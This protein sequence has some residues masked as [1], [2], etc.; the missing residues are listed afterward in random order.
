[1]Y[2]TLLMVLGGSDD[3]ARDRGHLAAASTSTRRGGLD[4]S[5]F[6]SR[7]YPRIGVS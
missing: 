1:V 7:R 4:I 5:R 2:L 3:A 6:H